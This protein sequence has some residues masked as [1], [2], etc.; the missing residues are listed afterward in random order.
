M[1]QLILVVNRC[2]ANIF[3]AMFFLFTGVNAAFQYLLVFTD[4]RL[5]HP[6]YVFVSDVIGLCYGPVLYLYYRYLLVEKFNARDLLHFVPAALFLAYFFLYEVLWAGP[7]QYENYIDQPQH[8]AVL[9]AIMLSNF[10][11]LTL[12][13]FSIRQRKSG[14]GNHEFHLITL[15]EFLIG[16]L[17]L[18]SV[19]NVFVFGFHSIL[20]TDIMDMV[21]TIK[22]MVF[23]GTNLVII[24]GAQIFFLR[25]PEVLN[26]DWFERDTQQADTS[27]SLPQQKS[28][29][30]VTPV[31]PPAERHTT[32]PA[33]AER[34]TPTA[35]SGN[36]PPPP[37]PRSPVP[38][39]QARACIERLNRLVDDKRMF[40]NA[41][42]TEKDLAEALEVPSYYLSKVLNQHLGK[43]FNE[44]INERRV[45]EA[46]RLL[47]AKESANRTMFAISLDSGF[48]S[49]SVFYTN[50]KKFSGCTP[51]VYK[52]RHQATKS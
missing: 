28:P 18:K 41:E 31:S 21:R 50:F 1:S 10:V 14:R 3:L 23:I 39:E 44:Y 38:D 25:Y 36:E 32:T 47:T 29:P 5:T 20:G 13:I 15:L 51:R 35:A 52:L 43:R 9:C 4:F 7:F 8:V 49:E 37:P 45:A 34:D 16:A 40:L 33:A 17:L 30:A 42:L 2:T 48:K 46:Q 24:T 11:Y 12:C 6:E 26:R 27:D 22:D 19:F